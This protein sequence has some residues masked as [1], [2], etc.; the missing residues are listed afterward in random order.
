MN[1]GKTAL[2]KWQDEKFVNAL[3]GGKFATPDASTAGSWI[4][5]I[6]WIP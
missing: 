6:R 4:S 1:G 5:S 2:L 3:N